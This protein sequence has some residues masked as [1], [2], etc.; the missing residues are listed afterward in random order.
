MTISGLVVF[1]LSSI[2][3][4]GNKNLPIPITV[5]GLLL[6]IAA[7]FTGPALALFPFSLKRRKKIAAHVFLFSFFL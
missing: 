6:G 3:L 7:T 4:F 5:T 2:D 1:T